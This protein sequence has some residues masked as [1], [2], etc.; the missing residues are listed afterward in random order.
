VNEYLFSAH[1]C[2]P[3]ALTFGTIYYC[4]CTINEGKH[5]KYEDMNQDLTSLRYGRAH[6]FIVTA[7]NATE[8]HKI[9]RE[10]NP[11]IAEVGRPKRWRDKQ[12]KYWSY[13]R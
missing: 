5:P 9:L 3:K 8:A 12:A 4:G 6:N 7:K 11:G 10:K 1:T 2:L 13:S